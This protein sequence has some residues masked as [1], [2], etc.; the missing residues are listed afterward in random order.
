M[1]VSYTRLGYMAKHEQGT[2][3]KKDAKEGWEVGK[4][5]RASRRGYP[6]PSPGLFGTSIPGIVPNQP[7]HFPVNELSR[8]PAS[9]PRISL[10][11][12]TRR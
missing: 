3:W 2:F 9:D 7:V 6:A 8:W 1:R 12:L 4:S 10:G 11:T 5:E